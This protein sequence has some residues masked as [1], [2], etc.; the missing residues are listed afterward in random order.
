[1]VN[2]FRFWHLNYGIYLVCISVAISDS[3]HV[4][5]NKEYKVFVHCYRHLEIFF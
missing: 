4:V 1:M 5:E 2:F 3:V